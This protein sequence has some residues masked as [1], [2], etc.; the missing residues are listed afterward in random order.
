MVNSG[1]G[2]DRESGLGGLGL[3][4][5]MGNE[6]SAGGFVV[7]EGVGNRGV[8]SGDNAGDWEGGRESGNTVGSDAMV[9]SLN[10]V[11]WDEVKEKVEVIMKMIV[12]K[13][14]KEAI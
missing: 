11:L 8:I 4:G 10:G 2:V 5:M 1:C 7:V 13:G 12:M 3:E 9:D 14:F 6:E